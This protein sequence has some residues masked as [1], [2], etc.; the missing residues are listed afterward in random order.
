MRIGGFQRFSLCDYPGEA[1]AIIFTL[2]CNYRCRY[3]HN[4]ELVL[5]ER[6]NQEIPLADVLAFLERRSG[7]L[8][9]VTITGGEPTLQPDLLD[10]MRA[11]K[12][13]GY[14][15]KLDTNG[16][17]PTVLAAVLKEGLA[18]YVA[19]DVKAP[20]DRYGRVTK[21]QP[22]EERLKESV[23]LIL[24]S[25]VAHEFRT[26]VAKG[27]TSHDDLRGIASTLHG[28]ERYFLQKFVPTKHVDAAMEKA[29]SYSDSELGALA[30]ELTA[31]VAFCG[32]R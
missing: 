28:A 9:A 5:P 27:V 1:A 4:P 18:N 16:S 2:G 7:Q 31:H 6:Y 20:L 29:E 26:T 24:R 32:V 10:V 17:R 14:L 19:M 21:L 25:G 8:R 22:R 23:G 11:I 3:C 13:M 30:Q 15:V 12:K